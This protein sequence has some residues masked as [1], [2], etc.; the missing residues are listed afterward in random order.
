MKGT[1]IF[2]GQVLLVGGVV[3]AFIWTATEWTAWRLA[4]QPEFGGALSRL[5]RKGRFDAGPIR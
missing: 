5:A 2:W 3:L 1:K 4:F